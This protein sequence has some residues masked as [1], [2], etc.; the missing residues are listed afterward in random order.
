MIKALI[1]LLALFAAQPVLASAATLFHDG[2]F[3]QAAIA[4]RT[5]NSAAA[6]ILAGRAT[7]I[8]AS[9][10]TTSHDKA[11]DLVESADRDF[12]A[13]LAKEP[14]DIEAEL[15]KAQAVGYLG[16]LTKSPGLAK[17]TRARL[18][19]VLAKDPNNAL[20]WA[21]LAGWHAGAVSAVG[22]FLAGT[23]LGASTKTAIA[24]FETALAKDPK[25]LVNPAFYALTL[26][27]LS[28]ENAP[29]ASQ[30]LQTVA[31]LPA[32]DAYE[33]LL[34]RETAQLLPLLASGDVK[35]AQALARKLLP[36][37]KLT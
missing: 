23:L 6:L 22:K 8:V 11:R 36:F 34:K 5:E 4:G 21:S 10:E 29:R 20:A 12:D 14:S 28:T 37:G 18:D 27:D 15:M 32:R 35:G 9:F 1:A 25:T 17:E 7:L 2:Q 30:L 26:L 33:M 24:D 19:A 3:A 13:A 31:R 16:K